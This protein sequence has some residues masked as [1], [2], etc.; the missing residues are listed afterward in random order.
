MRISASNRSVLGCFLS[1]A[2]LDQL[3]TSFHVIHGSLLRDITNGLLV[4]QWETA[5]HCFYTKGNGS[6]GVFS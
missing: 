1:E 4:I 5:V 6:R 2:F 3:L